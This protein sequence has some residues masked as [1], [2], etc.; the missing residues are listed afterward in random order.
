M[1][2]ATEPRRR[3]ETTMQLIRAA[4]G[5]TVERTGQPIFIGQVWGRA[6][7]SAETSA[8]FALNVVQF[9]AGARTRP[10]RHSSDQ[11]LYVVS[12]IGEVGASGRVER[13]AA[14]DTVLIPAGESH[15]HGAGDTGSPM[16]HLALTRAGSETIV[17]P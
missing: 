3:E 6:L 13:V 8:D 4:E 9:A 7:A 15:W 5:D 10:H 16:S 1:V 14:G 17:E 11:L 12:G 2:H